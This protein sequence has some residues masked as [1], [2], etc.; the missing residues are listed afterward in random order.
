MTRLRPHPWEQSRELSR[1]PAQTP[2]CADGGLTPIHLYPEC[3]GHGSMA[4]NTLTTL[5]R[6]MGFDG[7][8]GGAGV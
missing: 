2:E 6:E 5:L 8:R 3:P 4:R 1:G 7:V